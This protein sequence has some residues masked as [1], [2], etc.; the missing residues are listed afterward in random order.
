MTRQQI[1]KRT[2]FWIDKLGLHNWSIY[3]EFKK[4]KKSHYAT[5]DF[6]EIASTTAHPQYKQAGIVFHP[7]KTNLIDDTTIVHELLHCLMSPLIA[8]AT[9]TSKDPES[10]QYYNEMITSEL[11]MI[12]TR[13]GGKHA[14][15]K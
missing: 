9:E 6:I 11:D 12:I 13:L 8:V 4:P 1:I 15:P 7:T 2:S 3:V 10:V 14:N 5:K